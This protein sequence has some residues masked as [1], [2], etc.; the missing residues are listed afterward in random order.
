[1]PP[2]PVPRALEIATAWGWRLLVVA[3]AGYVFGFLVLDR[4]RLVAVPLLLAVLGA[5][6]TVRLVVVDGLPPAPTAPA[7]PCASAGVGD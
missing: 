6:S 1:M 7:A 3:L 4:V 5:D 2:V